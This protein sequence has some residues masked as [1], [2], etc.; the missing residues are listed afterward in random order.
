MKDI[1]LAVFLLA[2]VWAAPAGAQT[3]VDLRTQGKNVDFSAG[4]S[5][6]PFQ[7]GTL[8][9]ASCSVGAVFFNTNA[10]AG[11]N[12]FA[13]TATN[14]WT[15]ESGA[16]GLPAM[17]GNAN[18][19]LSNNGTTAGWQALGGDLNGA[20]QAVTVTG[21]QGHPIGRLAPADGQALEWSGAL[22]LW[23]PAAVAALGGANFSQAFT[24]QTT[25]LIP[26]SVHNLGTSNLIVDCYNSAAPAQMIEA[27]SITVDAST[28][29]VTVTF[30]NPQ[31]GR[32]VING[33][34]TGLSPNASNVFATG[35]IQTFQ[36]ALVATGSSR[37]APDQ[38]GTTLPATCT[39]GDQFFN[40]GAG[41]GQNLYFCTASNT[42]TQMSGSGGSGP[43][44]SV[45]GRTGA[46][47]AQVGDYAFSQ[48][49]GTATNTQ[50]GAGIDAAKIGAGT[51]TNTIWG[52]LANLSSDVQAQLNGK[53]PVNPTTGGDLSGPL[54][55][56]TVRGIQ[57]RSVSAA[58]PTNGQALVWSAATGA[59]QPG[60]VAGGSGGMG[61]QLGDF[62]VTRSSSTVLV[63]G[64]NCS[65]TTPCNARF[66]NTVYSFTQSCT[67]TLSTGT[68]TA[69]VYVSGGGTLTIGHN[70]TVAA[71]AGC[72]AQS[73]VTAF[74]SNAIPLYNWTATSGTWDATGG[75]DYRGWL[76]QK[77]IS[78]GTGIATVESFGQTVVGVDASVVP[79]Y[80]ASTAVLN[81]PL[82][83]NGACATD[84]T[85]TLLG[86]LAGNSVAPAWPS[87]FEPG[88]LGIMFVSAADTIT[89]RVCNLSG[90]AVDPINAAFGATIVRNF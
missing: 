75:K 22:G 13:C 46:V 54:G 40:T 21:I 26:G 64:A 58:A 90:A 42:W 61:S 14:V 50:L 36:G 47:S 87:A 24:S 43:V 11:Q 53:S 20:P 33:T 10:P 45:F 62:A 60:T 3:Q 79:T 8:L 27:N 84:Q 37:T 38:A 78:A 83:A 66:G 17:A 34:G 48:L 32:C 82:I 25:V 69:Y 51:V 89:V 77:N 63:I 7:T 44:S 70:L 88:L 5:T 80:L 76:S 49:T 71:S 73:S 35:T 18:T 2:A 39:T 81:F 16:S 65:S 12:L 55:S 52:Y 74:P 57:T 30:A 41:A 19:V 68:G 72:V 6:K 31:S 86:A 59:W 28:F 56:A 23:Q 15:L 29:N 67:A 9:P 4:P 1:S 85:F